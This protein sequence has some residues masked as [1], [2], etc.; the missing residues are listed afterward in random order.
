ME[1]AG[2]QCSCQPKKS[3]LEFSFIIRILPGQYLLCGFFYLFYGEK[4]MLLQLHNL[5][6][7]SEST[8]RMRKGFELLCTVMLLYLILYLI[9]L[10]YLEAE[11]SMRVIVRDLNKVYL[12]CTC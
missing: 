9:N 6:R 12:V 2:N 7:I 8:N 1:I 5:E 3:R 4:A 11:S 10:L